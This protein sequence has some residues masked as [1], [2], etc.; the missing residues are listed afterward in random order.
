MITFTYTLFNSSAVIAQALLDGDRYWPSELKFQGQ[1]DAE[2]IN[3]I[4]SANAV[5]IPRG[6]SLVPIV[7]NAQRQHA[8]H[9]D[10]N[11]YVA[12]TIARMLGQ[13]GKLYINFPQGGTI[14]GSNCVCSSAPG[15]VIGIRSYIDFT[16]TCGTIS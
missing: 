12:V 2:I 4:R 15:N 5:P 6:N 14:V 16:F 10:A 13:R 7:F 8:S 1:G 9:F 11:R 3:P